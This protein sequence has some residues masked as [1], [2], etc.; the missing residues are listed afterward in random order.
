MPASAIAL[1]GVNLD[2]LRGSPLYAK[3]PPAANAFLEPFRAAHSFLI[4]FTGAELLTIAHGTVPGATQAAPDLAI[5]GSPALIAAATAPHAPSAI[6][7]A[8]GTVA[9][10][11]P[12]WIAVRGGAPLPLQ[13]NL[14]NAN[15]LVSLAESL[16]VG[17]ALRD[18]VDLELTARCP[19]SAAA[20]EFERRLRALV[21]LTI[22]ANARQPE[23]A[24][25]LRSVQLR[26]DEST[27][28][29]TLSAPPDALGK[30]LP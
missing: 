24:A 21:S 8:A 29:A 17:L 20:A 1:A 26:R 23:L 3:L 11:H 6:L 5:L 18:V 10:R 19:S 25:L 7:A 28:H 22:A 9:A 30:L 14:A 12:I 27:V 16:T 2:Q 15:N 13:G 4:A